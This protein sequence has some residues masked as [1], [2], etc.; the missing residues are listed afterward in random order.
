M[1]MDFTLLLLLRHGL[2]ALRL[3]LHLV[4]LKQKQMSFI[5]K[6]KTYRARL[7]QYTLYELY[8]LLTS[9]LVH[10]S[11]FSTRLVFM[12][13][14]GKPFEVRYKCKVWTT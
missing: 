1:D 10:E 6:T 7:L 8:Q 2:D 4:L 3:I 5:S 11:Y 12:I 13:T 9:C 14:I